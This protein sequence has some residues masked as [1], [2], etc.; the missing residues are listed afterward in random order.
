[1]VNDKKGS[2][3][4]EIIVPLNSPRANIIISSDYGVNWKNVVEKTLPLGVK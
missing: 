1:M 4:K 3:I 2:G